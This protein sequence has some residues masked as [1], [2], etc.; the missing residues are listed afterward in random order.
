MSFACHWLCY[1]NVLEVPSTAGCKLSHIFAVSHLM[2]CFTSTLRTYRMS[3]SYPECLKPDTRLIES[4]LSACRLAEL[5]GSDVYDST[6]VRR[7]IGV[8]YVTEGDVTVN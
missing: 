4:R 8:H 5:V 3:R 6:P 1:M 7:A 2:H